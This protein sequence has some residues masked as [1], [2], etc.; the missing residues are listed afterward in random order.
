MKTVRIRAANLKTG[1][2]IDG[3]RV[4]AVHKYGRRNRSK[5][6]EKLASVGVLA[7]TPN[8]HGNE[9]DVFKFVGSEFVCVKRPKYNMNRK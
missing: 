5:A 2:V 4:K 6:C 3:Q 1:D 7:I 9:L 8:V